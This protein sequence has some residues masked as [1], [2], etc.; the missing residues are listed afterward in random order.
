MGV[1]VGLLV[2]SAAELLDFAPV[3]GGLM[4]AH[5]LWHGLTPPLS[6]LFYRFVIADAH[7]HVALHSDKAAHIL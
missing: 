3:F 2:A 4:D 7:E 1:A 6:V 5:A